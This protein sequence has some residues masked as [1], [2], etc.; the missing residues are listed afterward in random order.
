MVTHSDANP[1]A[2]IVLQTLNL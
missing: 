2:M 1:A